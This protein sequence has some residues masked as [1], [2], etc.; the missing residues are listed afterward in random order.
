MSA[1]AT[2][3]AIV[4]ERGVTLTPAQFDLALR[5]L[6]SD[7]ATHERRVSAWKSAGVEY[8]ADAAFC[9]VA[10]KAKAAIRTAMTQLPSEEAL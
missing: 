3:E 8:D 2:L 4:S 7:I 6:E 1:K 9:N 5:T 10:A